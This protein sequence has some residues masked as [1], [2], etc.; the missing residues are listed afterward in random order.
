VWQLGRLG[1]SKLSYRMEGAEAVGV[2]P[3]EYPN[4]NGLVR[5]AVGEHPPGSGDA[6]VSVVIT[7]QGDGRTG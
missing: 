2:G 5:L 3:E 4:H 6:G 7:M 1:T